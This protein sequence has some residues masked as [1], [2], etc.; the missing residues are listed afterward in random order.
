MKPFD[1]EAFKR[2]D[3]AITR[4]GKEATFLFFEP[5]FMESQ[6][7]GVKIAGILHVVSMRIDGCCWPSRTIDGFDLI[8][9]K[10]KTR[11]V[12]QWVVV[13]KSGKVTFATWH[14]DD[15]IINAS[16]TF[17]ATIHRVE[18]ELEDD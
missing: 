16:R 7:L 10:P 4:D 6:Q 8:G 2:G 18:I 3:V 13:D 1:F 15:A 9:M 14:K 17:G 12:E 11:K 5:Q